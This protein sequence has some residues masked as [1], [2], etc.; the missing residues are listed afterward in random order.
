[1]EAA[2]ASTRRGVSPN[3]EPS[4]RE[5]VM[6]AAMAVFARRGFGQARVQEIAREAGLTTGALYSNFKGKEELFLAI[7]RRRSGGFIRDA[8]SLL[9][10]ATPEELARGLGA[11]LRHAY[12]DV[13]EWERLWLELALHVTRDP[14]QHREFLE[15]RASVRKA[16]QR[17]VEQWQER[18]AMQLP[19]SPKEL[20][21]AF[22]VML[23]G[24]S[25][26]RATM[27]PES[28]PKRLGALLE[29]MV[30][31][32]LCGPIGGGGEKSAGSRTRSDTTAQ[33]A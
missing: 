7:A 21:T 30:A 32:M 17:F 8:D 20:A 6:D 24:L 22:D 14:E 25:F 18:H 16:M 33:V 27:G 3:A 4:T 5:R 31:A 19:A 23:S 2:K 28:F 29:Q 1:M 15:Q 11:A 12:E 10:A 9:D 13:P 26:E